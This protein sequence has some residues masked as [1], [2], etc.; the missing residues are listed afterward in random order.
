MTF[1]KNISKNLGIVNVF[2]RKKKSCKDLTDVARFILQ[3]QKQPKQ[4]EK[5]HSLNIKKSRLTFFKKIIE[6]KTYWIDLDQP[7]ST[8]KIY[9]SGYEIIITS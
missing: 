7:R 5:K 8:C 6:T 3:I 2:S 9:D 4:L 1:F